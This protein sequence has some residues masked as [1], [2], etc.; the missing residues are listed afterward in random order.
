MVDQSCR[1]DSFAGSRGTLDQAE[2]LLQYTL[3][4]VELREEEEIS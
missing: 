4:S 3:D 1:G 2:G